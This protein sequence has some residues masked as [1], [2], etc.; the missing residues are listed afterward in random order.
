M[1]QLRP[2]DLPFARQQTVKDVAAYGPETYRAAMQRGDQNVRPLGD[3]YSAANLI[4][5]NEIERLTAA[6]LFHVTAEMMALAKAAAPTLPSFNLMPE[7]IP[8]P[9]GFVYFETPMDTGPRADQNEADVVGASWGPLD[10]HL[11]GADWSLGGLW[12]TWYTS[13]DSMLRSG[14][15]RG[16]ITPAQADLIAR[17]RGPLLVDNETQVGFS[18]GPAISQNGVMTAW[19][20]FT[21]TAR[22]LLILKSIWLLMSQSLTSVEDVKLDRPTRRRMQR[23]GIDPPRVRIIALRRPRSDNESEATSDREWHH[24]WVVRGHWRMQPYGP[25]RSRVRP[26]WI[27]P[28]VKGPEGAPLL[29]GEKVYALRR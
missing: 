23:A 3:D 10:G 14:V 24:R 11:P 8:A 28:H 25:A 22:W 4:V 19:E 7:D 5:K 27:A 1:T 2:I 13:R 29:G 6:E 16:T 15:E 26:V 18:T 20:D 21:G 9:A 12:I 17:N